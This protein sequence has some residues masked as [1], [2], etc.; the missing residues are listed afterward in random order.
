MNTPEVA[1]SAD[2]AARAAFDLVIDVRSPGEF[3]LDHVPGAVNLP[4]LD[5][6]ERAEV[7]TIYVQE[8]RFKA[9]R[10]GAAHVARNVARHLQTA[11]ADQPGSFHPLIY[12]WRGGMRSNAMALILSQVGWRVGV[13]A[14]GYMTYRR[15]ITARLYDTAPD[16]RVVLLDGPTGSGKTEVLHRLAGHGV[17]IVDLEGLAEHRGSLL[18]RL[19]DREQPSQ[20][21]FESRL[22]AALE[23]LDPN[24]PVVVEAESSKVGERMV[25]P[26]LWRAMAGAPR[27]TLSAPAP[28]RAAYLAQAYSHLAASP[29]Q[30]LA[31]LQR[32][33]SHPGPRQLAGWLEMAQA[34]ALAELAAALIEQ[35]YD[36]A[37]RRSG[38]R[39]GGANLGEYAMPDLGA[40][41]V[42]AAAAAVA[43]ILRA[44]PG[45]TP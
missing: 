3:A 27:I 7:G 17:Q 19:P 32:L 31:T 13:L 1:P 25:P 16:L 26:V 23:A 18:G 21:M 11:L 4:V 30:L 9:R 10:V 20:K 29:P 34:G 40:T 12:C 35:H 15:E 36:P 6:A 45:W 24:R 28:A 38:R 5:D 42:E 14:G 22:A 43:G 37:Y 41:A 8:S 44:S 33:P 39:A 2:A